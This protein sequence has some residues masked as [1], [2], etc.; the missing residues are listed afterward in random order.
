MIFGFVWNSG[1]SA[2]L[3]VLVLMS[4]QKAKVKKKKNSK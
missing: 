2:L 4:I 3:V 1:W